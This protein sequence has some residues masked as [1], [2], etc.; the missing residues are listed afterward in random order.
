[1]YINCALY[2]VQFY[3]QYLNSIKHFIVHFIIFLS[4]FL[5]TSVYF[6]NFLKTKGKQ[7]HRGEI[8]D[9]VVKRSNMKITKLVKRMHI[10]RGTYYNHKVDPNLSLEL[11]KQY[12][13][14]LKYDFTADIPEMQK[15]KLEEPMALYSEPTTLEEAI[16]QRDFWKQEADKWKDKYIQVLEEKIKS[17]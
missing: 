1:M 3:I 13:L 15:Y 2:N 12:G 16:Q 10:S 5:N 7:I 6:F 14:I 8:L 4:I 11:I 17:D 9:A